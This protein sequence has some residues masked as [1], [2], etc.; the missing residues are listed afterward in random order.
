VKIVKQL[1]IFL[2]NKPGTLSKVCRAL[3]HEEINLYA[4]MVSDTVDHA[5]IRIMVSDP[6]KAQKMFESSGVLV[7]A[8]DVIQIDLKNE[9][10]QLAK[11]SDTLSLGSVNIHYA[12][13]ATEQ[14]QKKG[15]FVLHVDDTKKALALLKGFN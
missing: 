4:M 14:E 5:V 6:D 3:A 7:I 13:C 2:Q 9:P 12:Y 10:G 1:S 15:I 8:T 11:L